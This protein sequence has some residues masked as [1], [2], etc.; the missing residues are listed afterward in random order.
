M[1]PK[2]LASVLAAV[3][4]ASVCLAAAKPPTDDAI[5]DEVRIKLTNDPVVK[6]RDMKADVK[7]GV[8]TLTGNV[9]EQKQADR[10]T[11]IAKKVK[12]VKQVINQITV[13]KTGR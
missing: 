9:S 1:I 4:L 10:A 12:G 2:L 3:L 11:K 8:V 13:S 6:I 5:S 7:D